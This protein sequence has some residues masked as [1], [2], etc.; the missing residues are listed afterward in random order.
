ME[1]AS[2]RPRAS[3]QQREHRALAAEGARFRCPG[4]PRVRN[5]GILS[6][7]R[8]LNDE[9]TVDGLEHRGIVQA[10]SDRHRVQFFSGDVRP[11][12]VAGDETAHGPAFI[13]R[14]HEMIEPVSPG[15]PQSA[16]MNRLGQPVILAWRTARPEAG[17]TWNSEHSKFTLG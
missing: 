7:V 9:G 2:L 12:A 13:V 16:S 10:V 8:Q 4:D 15:E 5:I 11:P 17:R 3:L 6:A 1:Q 14:T